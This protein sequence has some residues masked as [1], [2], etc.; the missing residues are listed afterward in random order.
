MEFL[1]KISE[2]KFQVPGRCIAEHIFPQS[3]KGN[4]SIHFLQIEASKKVLTSY[5]LKIFIV[6]KKEDDQNL[7]KNAHET[8]N[9][10]VFILMEYP[11]ETKHLLILCPK[12]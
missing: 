3:S 1:K 7:M 9:G 11:K 6:T 12:D 2:F 5:K 4:A 10:K 8:L